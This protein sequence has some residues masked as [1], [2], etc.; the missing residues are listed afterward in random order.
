MEI[1][2][3]TSIEGDD[4]V[5]VAAADLKPPAPARLDQ[6]SGVP[7]ARSR[8]PPPGGDVRGRYNSPPTQEQGKAGGS[9]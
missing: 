7:P 8:V 9:M 1:T 4:A 2:G 5:L 3:I 6:A